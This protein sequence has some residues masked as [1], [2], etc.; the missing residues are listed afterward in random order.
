MERKTRSEMFSCANSLMIAG[1]DIP[2]PGQIQPSCG[3]PQS[4]LKCIDSP[5][6]KGKVGF[7]DAGARLKR[8]TQRFFEELEDA[9]VCDDGGKPEDSKDRSD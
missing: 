6:S 2:P 8:H 7:V 9:V 1:R 5:L 3:T 4:D